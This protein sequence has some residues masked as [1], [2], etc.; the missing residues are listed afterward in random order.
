MEFVIDTVISFLVSEFP[1]FFSFF[2]FLFFSFGSLSVYLFVYIAVVVVGVVVTISVTGSSC[3]L[4]T[5]VTFSLCILRKVGL[6]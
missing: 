5:C 1:Q 2:F 4:F 6:E 3:P